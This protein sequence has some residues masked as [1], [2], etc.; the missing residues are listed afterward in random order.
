VRRLPGGL[1]HNIISH[2]IARVAE[3]FSTDA[4][5][6]IAHG[7]ISPWL[8][9]LGETQLVDE[10]RVIISEED[11]TTAYFTFSSQM[12]PALHEF[13]IYGPKNGL[14]LDQDHEI[15][16][17]LRG[18][19]FKSYVEKFVPPLL[20]AAQHLGNLFVNA[21]TFIRRDFHMKSGMK[22]LIESFYR[23]IR[24]GTP[25]PIPYEEILRTARIMDAIFDQLDKPAWHEADLGLR[26]AAL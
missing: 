24:E 14:V 15:V 1:L 8:R 12:R 5:Q 4:P 26:R 17:R 6:V 19:R 22:Y 3:F 2:G 7:F 13:R 10:L 11:R 9:T 21:R 20:F 18:A 23:S 16:L 25:V